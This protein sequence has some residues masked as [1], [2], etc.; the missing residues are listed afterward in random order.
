MVSFYYILKGCFLGTIVSPSL[1]QHV[2]LSLTLRTPPAWT[3]DVYVDPPS[4]HNQLCLRIM[5]YLLQC[6]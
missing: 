2:H 3:I 6:Y 5:C 4:L 1:D